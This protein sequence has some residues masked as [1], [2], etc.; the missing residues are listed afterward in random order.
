ML[1]ERKLL[2]FDLDIFRADN[3]LAVLRTSIRDHVTNL[4]TRSQE[5]GELAVDGVFLT[6]VSKGVF[7]ASADEA[8]DSFDVLF[9]DDGARRVN[10]GLLYANDA[11]RMELGC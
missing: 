8:H 5:T 2:L 3:P 7:K 10:L 6:V 4:W 11:E 1:E 9:M